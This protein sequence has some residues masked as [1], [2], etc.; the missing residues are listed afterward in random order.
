M[1]Q[2]RQYF[3]CP[4]SHMI[5]AEPVL[6]DDGHFYEK[7][8]IK[9][10]MHTK[11][12]S[13]LT[14]NPMSH[15]LTRSYEFEALLNIFLEHNPFEK[16][17]QYCTLKSHLD[18]VNQVEL[19]V[20]NKKYD[21]LYKYHQFD[22]DILSR[23]GKIHTKNFN[24]DDL[25][26]ATLCFTI[27]LQEADTSII[28][29]VMDNA[30]DLESQIAGGKLIHLVCKNCSFD[31]VKYLV[32]KGVD[33]E[34]ETPKRK[35][36]PIHFAIKSSHEG[37]VKYLVEKGVNIESETSNGW[38]PIHLICQHDY[39]NNIKYFLSLN[40]NINAKIKSYG[41]IDDADYGI[42]ELIILNELLDPKEKLELIEFVINLETQQKNYNK[43]V[44]S[45]EAEQI[46]TNEVTLEDT[47][48]KFMDVCASKKNLN[49]ISNIM[50]NE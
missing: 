15:R 10:W 49:E 27:F 28:K 34:C 46:S 13:P 8:E 36:R 2:L 7:K 12:S 19:F 3:I 31:V 17:N 44:P 4:I 40:P 43:L 35:W 47:D 6:A 16:E 30:I 9:K 11:N 22:L 23:S 18:H 38:K 42:K 1:L 14:N 37:I 21:K 26:K 48:L 33:I 50:M 32:E 20:K 29:Y 39:I 5:F 41:D 45:T 24:N 25:S